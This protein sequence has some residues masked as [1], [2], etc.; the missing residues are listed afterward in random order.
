VIALPHWIGCSRVT[1]VALMPRA[2][3]EDYRS[4]LAVKLCHMHMQYTRMPRRSLS[5]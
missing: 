4:D 1:T 5:H 3:T 2:L